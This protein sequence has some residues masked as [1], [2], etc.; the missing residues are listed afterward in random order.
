MNSSTLT[1]TVQDN[2]VLEKVE[3]ASSQVVNRLRLVAL[4]L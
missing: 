3:R 4:L 1:S 2:L